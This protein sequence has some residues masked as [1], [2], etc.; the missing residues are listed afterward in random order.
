MLLVSTLANTCIGSHPY[1]ERMPS[2]ARR[3]AKRCCQL[4]S[5]SANNRRQRV[6]S[7]PPNRHSARRQ[8]YWGGVLRLGKHSFREILQVYSPRP[9][10]WL[11]HPTGN[12]DAI[13][14]EVSRIK[15]QSTIGLEALARS[16]KAYLQSLFS[17]LHK[18]VII[19]ASHLNSPHLLGE[20]T[21]T[22][23]ERHF[24]A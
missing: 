20:P 14:L 9:E 2:E 24:T 3:P 15:A 6:H 19:F 5:S 10:S 1:R 17:T 16:V 22:T 23:A 18:E 11:G 21:S 4:S 12:T 13:R 7:S 8:V